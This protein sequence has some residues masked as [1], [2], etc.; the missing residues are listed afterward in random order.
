MNIS[1]ITQ[2]QIHNRSYWVKEI[3]RISGDFGADSEKIEHK[4]EQEILKKRDRC[5]AWTLKTLWCN[6]RKI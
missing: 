6:P 2:E 4:I 5:T 3:S 1:V